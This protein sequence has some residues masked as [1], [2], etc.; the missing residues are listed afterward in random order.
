MVDPGGCVD[1]PPSQDTFRSDINLPPSIPEPTY[2]PLD[3]ATFVPPQSGPPPSVTIEFCDR[4]RWRV[5]ARRL[6]RAT[7]T[8]TE[9]FVTFPTP[10]LRSITIIP[11]NGEDTSGRFRVWLSYDG[12][13]KPILIWDRKVEGKFPELKDLKQ[14]IRDRIQPG[15]SLG[16]SDK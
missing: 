8:S 5:F 15:K 3:P 13:P 16:H 6:H 2:D 9:L 12:E 7:W 11:L 10:A 14:R 4:C 1:C